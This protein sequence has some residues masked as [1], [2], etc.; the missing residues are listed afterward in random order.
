[1]LRTIPG[2]DEHDFYRQPEGRDCTHL[3][4]DRVTCVRQTETG[5]EEGRDSKATEG[6]L[7]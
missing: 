3:L 1:M 2:V 5:A 4:P 7:S 6:T